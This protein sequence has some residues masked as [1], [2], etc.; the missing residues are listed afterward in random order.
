MGIVS[1]PQVG[2]AAMSALRILAGFA[3]L[4][5][6]GAGAFVAYAWHSAIG[7]VDPPARASFD[8][9][10]V[11]RGADLAAIGN[12]N[13]CHTAPGGEPFAG[14]LGI[15]TP[16]GTIYSTNITPDPQSGI[17]RWSEAAFI[18]S[19]R[20]GVDREGQHLYPAFPYDHYTL[21]TDQDNRALYAFLMTR[22]AV[23]AASPANELS[24][25]F[26]IRMLLAGW[27]ALYFREGP[28]QPDSNRSAE[29]NRGRYLVEG[30][31]HCGACH[32]PRN[33]LGGEQKDE[34]FAGAEVENWTVYPIN[35]NSPAPVPWNAESLTFYLRHGWHEHHGASRGSMAPVTAN[36]GSIPEADVRAIAAYVSDVMGHPSQARIARGE[37]ALATARKES[38][39]PF[40]MRANS[41]GNGV[42]E[43]I[44]LSACQGC[45]DGRRPVPFGGL[46][47]HLSSAVNAANAQNIINVTLFGLPAAKGEPSAIM[48]AYHGVLNP[49]QLVALLDYMR[50]RFSD[51]PAWTDTRER[52]TATMSGERE[53][54]IYRMDG[55][56]Q[57]PPETSMRTTPWP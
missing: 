53:V 33:R 41:T 24:F 6:L 17:G 46:N 47:L 50:D 12:C 22:K 5:V 49:D 48:P 36:L 1:P 2:L 10:L 39:A 7:P 51:Q 4:L 3:I 30:L 38:D 29:W 15:P 11:S 8:P 16:F 37:A 23:S 57:A 42:G 31:S 43:A 18:R 13:V 26:N 25:P 55:T 14:G 45:H 40:A 20:E 52:V 28:L 32:T 56:T 44:F 19:L 54:P 27:K 21:V 35:A 34:Y 9:A